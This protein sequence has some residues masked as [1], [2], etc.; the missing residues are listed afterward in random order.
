[1]ACACSTGAAAAWRRPRPA[2]SSTAS[3]RRLF[4]VQDEAPRPAGRRAGA[5]PRASADRRRLGAPCRADHGRAAR[6]HRRPHLRA[7]DRQLGRRAGAPAAP[8]GRRRGDGQERVRPAPACR[9]AAHRPRRAVRARPPCAGAARRRAACR[10][11]PGRR[12]CCAS[13][14]RS[15]ARCSSRRWRRPTSGPTPS[16]R[17]RPA[18]ACA[19]RWRRA[20]ASARCSRASSARTGAFVASLVTDTDLNVAEYAVCLQERRRVALVRA[21]MDEAARLAAA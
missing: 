20:S 18:R 5:D 4:A 12:W 21:F 13:A 9:A 10:R 1:M 16:S 15:R 7:V 2:G 11:W 19:R 17:C 6:A 14:A 8:R 3:P